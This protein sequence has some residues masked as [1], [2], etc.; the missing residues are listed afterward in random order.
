MSMTRCDFCESFI[1]TDDGD[2][3]VVDEIKWKCAVCIEDEDDA[4]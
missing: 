2:S 3:I 4:N 1:D